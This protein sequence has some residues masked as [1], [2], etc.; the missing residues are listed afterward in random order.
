MGRADQLRKRGRAGGGM[1][2]PLSLSAGAHTSSTLIY[3]PRG[4][5]PVLQLVAL[6]C[7]NMMMHWYPSITTVQ[8]TSRCPHNYSTKY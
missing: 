3:L 5:T 2:G 1:A 6:A 4:F 7:T 8:S